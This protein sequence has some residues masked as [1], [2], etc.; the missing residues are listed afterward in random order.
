MRDAVIRARVT[1]EYK[2]V[3]E[4]ILSHLGMSP[5]DA[6][7]LFVHQVVMRK[8]LPFEIAIPNTATINAINEAHAAENVNRYDSFADMVASVKVKSGETECRKVSANS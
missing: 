8:G 7:N 3:F 5:S 1:T 6:I 2:T 4:D